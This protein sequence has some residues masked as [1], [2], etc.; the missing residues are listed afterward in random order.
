MLSDRQ[1]KILRILINSS[2]P[3]RISD[4]A[5]DVNVS[6]RTVS[7]ELD[8]LGGYLNAHN[9]VLRRRPGVGI[10]IEHL[11]GEGLSQ[12]VWDAFDAA[13]GPSDGL[14]TVFRYL[15]EHEWAVLD[16]LT[17]NC[18][19]SRSAVQQRLAT[20]RS[21][22]KSFGL[23]LV[24]QRGKGISLIG[25]EVAWR[26]TL[27]RVLTD[28]SFLRSSRESSPMPPSLMV[29][30][31]QMDL[32]MPGF[33]LHRIVDLLRAHE[34]KLHVPLSE[35]DFVSIVAYAALAIWRTLQGHAFTDGSLPQPEAEGFL[36]Q[37]ATE[38]GIDP[39]ILFSDASGLSAVLCGLDPD[40][41]KDDDLIN[42]FVQQ[43]IADMETFLGIPFG[44]D[45]L[46]YKSLRLHLAAQWQ[47]KRIDDYRVA[48]VALPILHE[49]KKEYPQIFFGLRESVERWRLH[50]GIT[51]PVEEVGY[52][53]LHFGASLIRHAWTIDVAYVTAEPA[54]VAE[55]AVSK[56]QRE[57]PGIKIRPLVAHRAEH[58]LRNL[59]N[60]NLVIISE[61]AIAPPPLQVPVVHVSAWITDDD[62]RRCHHAINN[63]L[64]RRNE[65]GVTLGNSDQR[66]A[67]VLEEA[68]WNLQMVESDP[69]SAIRRLSKPLMDKYQM[70][71]DFTDRVIA[72]EHLGY[73]SVAG[74]FA[75]PHVIVPDFESRRIG[76]SVGT[77]QYPVM[78][79]E[80][81]V[82]VIAVLALS[83]D[84]GPLFV[85]LYEWFQQVAA[86][87]R[88]ATSLSIEPERFLRGGVGS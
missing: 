24:T 36:R 68:I 51:L 63:V 75:F 27:H 17:E 66:L 32:I 4:I 57:F 26:R 47:R 49:V 22:I 70:S 14:W 74:G 60:I 41:D 7:A 64:Q 40:G 82:D 56:I 46:L 65:H 6:S 30:R 78:W 73:S 42:E 29:L 33:P 52:L 71:E 28:P 11:D 23:T 38:F 86:D 8:F 62:V 61:N 80:V 19:L 20:L 2:S 48:S 53:T 87:L 10:W 67:P 43:S 72:R 45:E 69:F 58:D 12:L 18:Y 15:S 88:T 37:L 50:S 5:G 34:E 39:A 35:Q 9:S 25:P 81:S 77:L 31:R 55:L 1:G 84:S 54:S 13:S 21:I 83:R 79:G 59:S 3:V 16:E 44:T 85:N 76:M